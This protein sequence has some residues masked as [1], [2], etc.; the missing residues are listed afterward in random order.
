MKEI[1]YQKLVRDL[2]PDHIQAQKETPV[3][4]ILDEAAF[5]RQLKI[6]LQEE[7]AEFLGEDEAEPQAQELADILEVVYALGNAKGYTP[8]ALEQLRL[9]KAEKNGGF[10]K[11]IYLE[12]KLRDY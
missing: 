5:Y 2:I 6:K 7:V 12:K 4:R 11:R 1:F 9:Q 10:E 8:E 3:I